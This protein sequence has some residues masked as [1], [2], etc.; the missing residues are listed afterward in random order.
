MHITRIHPEIH[1]VFTELHVDVTGPGACRSHVSMALALVSDFEISPGP[2]ADVALDDVRSAV[3]E[4]FSENATM[5]GKRE[6]ASW[7]LRSYACATAPFP[8]PDVADA[9]P[10]SEDGVDAQRM[11]NVIRVARQKGIAAIATTW[12]GQ[13]AFAD[14]ALEMG[15]VV[16]A[17]VEN[18][19]A[20]F[21]PVDLPR[22]KL[23]DR[24]LSLV[25]A[26]YLSNP[27]DYQEGPAFCTTCGCLFFA[28]G[29]RAR[30]RCDRH[31]RARGV[32]R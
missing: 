13:H 32:P 20:V 1:V 17:R 10:P 7:L 22:M 31:L 29:A 14:A 23:A 16:E 15:H 12:R 21:L 26:D 18:G 28:P 6:L 11:C 19:A 9:E 27:Q 25:A 4:F 5:W 2:S 24:V 30:G 3:L 8:H